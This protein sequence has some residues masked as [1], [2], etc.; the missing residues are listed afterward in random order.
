MNWQAIRSIYIFEMAR[1]WRTIIQSL[2]SPVVTTVLVAVDV[3]DRAENLDGLRSGH[4]RVQTPVSKFAKKG[5][6]YP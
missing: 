6:H 2:V 5:L 1:T 4:V 3:P